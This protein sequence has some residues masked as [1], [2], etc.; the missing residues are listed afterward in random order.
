MGSILMTLDRYIG[1]A[2]PEMPG[3]LASFGVRDF[4]RLKGLVVRSPD[5][6]FGSYNTE[7]KEVA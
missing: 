6:G 4:L 2:N 5:I 7:T 3:A 1:C